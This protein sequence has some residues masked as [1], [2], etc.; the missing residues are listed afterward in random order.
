MS[1]Y[2]A[3]MS[4]AGPRYAAISLNHHK[5]MV[6]MF[7]IFMLHIIRRHIRSLSVSLWTYMRVGIFLS[8]GT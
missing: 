3:H 7:R 4:Q 1:R 8:F 6:I 2:M 5:K